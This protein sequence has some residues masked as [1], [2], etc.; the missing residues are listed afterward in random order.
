MSKKPPEICQD[1]WWGKCSAGLGVEEEREGFGGVC[2][3]GLMCRW[4][5]RWSWR[6]GRGTVFLW[7]WQLS[8]HWWLR[9]DF[10]SL[11]LPRCR[12]SSA[13]IID[14]NELRN[15]GPLWN[16]WWLFENPALLLTACWLFD[17]QLLLTSIYLIIISKENLQRR[18]KQK[19][20]HF[21][22]SW[23]FHSQTVY[24]RCPSLFPPTHCRE[25]NDIPNTLPRHL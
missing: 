23:S 20:N 17:L 24:S 10:W 14:F 22:F 2:A 21:V 7:V 5:N 25:P 4:R 1:P 8:A 19:E 16:F 18:L 3:G 9:C 13:L 6:F 11:V 12:R 15:G